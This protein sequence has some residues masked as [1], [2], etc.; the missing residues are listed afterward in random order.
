L[1]RVVILNDSFAGRGGATDVAV[2]E[3]LALIQRGVAV[4]VISGDAG[5]HPALL[6]VGAELLSLSERPLLEVT[7]AAGAIRGLYNWR[8]A[9]LLDDWIDANDTPGTVYHL[10]NW[11]HILSPAIFRPLRRTKGRLVMTLHDYF[12]A[13]PNGGYLNYRNDTTCQ[14]TPLSAACL[15][16]DCDRRNYGHK[17][18]RAGRQALRQQLYTPSQ[19]RPVMLTLHEDMAPFI[20]RA[21][22]GEADLQV[23][24]NPIIPFTSTRVTAERN[25]L[26]VFVGRLEREKGPDLA[27]RAV[28]A[29]GAR[30]RF[31]G[32]GPVR[33]ELEQL[34]PHFEFAGWRAPSEI[35]ALVKDARGL[36]MSSR[37][38]EPFGMASVQALWS[39]LPVI[40]TADALLSRE[41]EEAGAGFACNPNDTA[42]LAACVTAL[43]EDDQRT[44]R[45]SQ[46]AFSATQ[47][48]GNTPARWTD[49]L[50]GVLAERVTSASAAALAS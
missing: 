20:L 6:N 29:A 28:H 48:L 24:R 22:I 10:H 13:C 31:I 26:F 34:Y 49:Q 21:D 23:L 42:A 45:M 14:L 3:V 36:L 38:P 12:I 5:D 41:I 37:V 27:A 8:A 44:A 40:A 32:D 47:H 4:T 19:E 33:A 1:E 15:G 25:D 17:L 18:W 50:I 43:A 2:M 9:K 7:R 35:G 16:T 30:M 39:G 46:R 11:A